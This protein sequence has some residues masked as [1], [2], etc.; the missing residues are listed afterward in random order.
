MR[1]KG[2]K[3]FIIVALFFV[4]LFFAYNYFQTSKIENPLDNIRYISEEKA[5]EV[6]SANLDFFDRLRNNKIEDSTVFKD[7]DGNQSAY[8]FEVTDYQG[9]AGYIV[10]AASTRLP[11]V[12]YSS[13]NTLTPVG[14]AYKTMNHIA[15]ETVWSV[16]DIRAEF[17]YLGGNEFF[18][19]LIF[20]DGDELI[21][22]YYLLGD[23]ESVEVLK[24]ELE[25]KQALYKKQA[26]EGVSAMWDE[27]F[28]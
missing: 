5:R 22:K 27:Y 10:I 20:R 1:K 12:L 18:V 2:L 3:R 15:S 28:K 6:A 9:K 25:Q 23:V 8:V 13:K 26:Q 11:P 17:I 21:E 24:E 7:L 19:K 14:V 16:A 4:I